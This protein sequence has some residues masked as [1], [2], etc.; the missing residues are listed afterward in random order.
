MGIEEKR[1]YTLFL[2]ASLSG[3]LL[4]PQTIWKGSSTASLPNP[5]TAVGWRESN[6][7]GF[8]AVTAG[9][10]YWCTFET[11][12]AYVTDILAPYFER[13][14]RALGLDLKTQKSI[15][16]I[17]VYSVHRGAAFR[18]WMKESHPNIF[19]NYIP[20][21]C[22]G[23]WQAM[24]TLVNRLAKHSL[25]RTSLADAV[26]E[27]QSLLASGL[28]AEKI[29]PTNLIGILRDRT[30]G[31]VLKMYHDLNKPEIIQKVNFFLFYFIF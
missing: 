29:K 15:F 27:T 11:M 6:E 31:A 5:K 22:T 24:D 9:E 17:D 13:Q 3:Y 10:T 19:L 7:L 12:K 26:D 30:V 1:A 8:K 14:I 18:E 16:Q 20:G 25:R 23:V 4:P 28:P 2:A 21:G